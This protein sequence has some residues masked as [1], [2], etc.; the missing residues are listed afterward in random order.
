MDAQTRYVAYHS[1]LVHVLR[2]RLNSGPYYTFRLHPTGRPELLLQSHA[3]SSG[4]PGRVWLSA[5]DL[6]AQKSDGMLNDC[7]QRT[8]SPGNAI[9]TIRR[10]RQILASVVAL[11]DRYREMVLDAPFAL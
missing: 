2:G 4:F 5:R 11:G 6:I 9:P 8:A 10:H 3:H 1:E 7:C